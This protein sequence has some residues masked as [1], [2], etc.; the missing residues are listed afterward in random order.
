MDLNDVISNPFSMLDF[1][2]IREPG[3]SVFVT[4]NHDNTNLNSLG[5]K[6]HHNIHD[7]V[8]FTLHICHHGYIQ[9]LIHDF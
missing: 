3:R 8:P 6:V 7:R 5:I 9:D 2:K 4:P 1:E